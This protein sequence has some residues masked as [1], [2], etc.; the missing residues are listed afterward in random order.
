MPDFEE[1]TPPAVDALRERQERRATARKAIVATDAENVSARLEHLADLYDALDVPWGS[2]PFTVIKALNERSYD[3]ISEISDKLTDTLA[4]LGLKPDAEDML[5]AHTI[6]S[7]KRRAEKLPQPHL[8]ESIP[9]FGYE[10]ITRER[11]RQITRERFGEEHDDEHTDHSLAIVAALYAVA[12]TDA[13]VVDGH[14]K[15]YW[16]ESWD[17]DWDKREEHDRLRQLSIAGALIA[18][19]I[20]RL[21]RQAE[22]NERDERAQILSRIDPRA[23]L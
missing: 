2:D 11:I 13:F 16:P 17:R 14:D 15:P 10:L 19:E 6:R 21:Q 23:D 12:G 9:L 5:I 1:V 18:A 20:D 4:E 22:E 7:L 3:D 8:Y